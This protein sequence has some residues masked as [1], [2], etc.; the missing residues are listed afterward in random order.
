MKNPMVLGSQHIHAQKKNG[1]FSTILGKGAPVIQE[2]KQP[3]KGMPQQISQ[4]MV[5]LES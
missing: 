2:T 4:K 1:L 3:K 5:Y